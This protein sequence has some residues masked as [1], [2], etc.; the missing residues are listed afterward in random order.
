ML[1]QPELGVTS[2]GGQPL[3]PHP[4]TPCAAV[5]QLEAEVIRL[6]S[7]ALMLGYFLTGAMAEL[8]LPPPAPPTRA[9]ELWRHTCFEAFVGSVGEEPYFEFNFATSGEWAAYR[10]SGYR[11]GMG[12]VGEVSAPRFQVRTTARTCELKISLATDQVEG[13]RANARW[14]LGLSAVIEEKAG[15]KSYWALAHPPGKADFHHADS[16]ARELP[17]MEP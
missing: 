9:D 17:P 13:L 1:G 11:T 7:N 2:I 12:I 15:G 8:S 6:P 5:E 14:R 4:R 3:R 10:F 16:F